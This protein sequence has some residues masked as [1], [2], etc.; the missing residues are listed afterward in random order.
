MVV[1]AASTDDLRCVVYHLQV[2]RTIDNNN[3]DAKLRSDGLR[4][5]NI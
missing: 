1:A 2:Y 4:L 5:S 3:A